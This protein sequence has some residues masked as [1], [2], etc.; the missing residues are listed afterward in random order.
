MPVGPYTLSWWS[1]NMNRTIGAEVGGGLC[2]CGQRPE[3]RSSL[4]LGLPTGSA[5][6]GVEGNGPDS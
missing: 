1:F 3:Q 5:F 2:D 4:G 6:W